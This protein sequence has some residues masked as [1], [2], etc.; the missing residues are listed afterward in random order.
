MTDD[1]RPETFGDL[2]RIIEEASG[3]FDEM[4]ATRHQEGAEKYGPFKFLEA[5]TLEEAMFELADLANYARYTF[6]KLWLLNEE[7]AGR[8]GDRSIN[9]GAGSFS[10]GKPVITPVSDSE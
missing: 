2:I 7:I 9:I 3:A 10:S 1:E 8:F 4:V 6:I 5:N